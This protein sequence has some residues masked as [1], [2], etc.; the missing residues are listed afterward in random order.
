MG[1]G[2]QQKANVNKEGG[3]GKFGN[4]VGN[5]EDP[6]KAYVNK[7]GGKFGNIV[8][9]IEDR[10]KAYVSKEGDGGNIGDKSGLLNASQNY[11]SQLLAD[12]KTLLIEPTATT[13]TTRPITTP[14]VTTRPV[15]TPAA[16]TPAVTTPTASAPAL[17]TNILF[18]TICIF[19]LFI[20]FIL[21][22][23]IGIAGFMIYRQRSS[24]D[25]ADE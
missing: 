16:T 18:I 4:I 1:F 11:A 17:S 25:T 3:G 20:L 23:I 21:F 24:S 9:N 2:D 14:T 10:Q 7:E 8:G 19:I 12:K 22:I 5:I 13:P 6:Q 15:T